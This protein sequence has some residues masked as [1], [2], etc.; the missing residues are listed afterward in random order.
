M[1]Y[2]DAKK[3]AFDVCKALPNG[4]QKDVVVYYAIQAAMAA[5]EQAAKNDN[6]L[7][8]ESNE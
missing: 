3:I 4:E 7:R 5:A 2:V 1:K 6:F 8:R